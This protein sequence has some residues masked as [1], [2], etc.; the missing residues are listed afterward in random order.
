IGFIDDYIKVF[1]KNK[2]GLAGKFKILGQVI[3]GLFVAAT[4]F[5]SDDV[6]VREQVQSPEGTELREIVIDPETGRQRM[7]YVTEDVKSTRTTIPFVKQ[8]EF[9]YEW[10]VSFAGDAA[11]WLKWLVYAFAIILIIT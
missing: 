8:N 3:L 5:I 6:M 7:Q 4:L 1:M 2:K 9:D 10:L 11:S